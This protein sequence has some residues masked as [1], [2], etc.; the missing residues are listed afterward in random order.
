MKKHKKTPFVSALSIS[1]ALIAAGCKDSAAPSQREPDFGQHNQPLQVSNGLKSVVG[2]VAVLGDS[3]STGGYGQRLSELIRYASQQKLSYFGAASSGRIGSWINGGFAPIPANAF[4]G[5]DAY[6]SD[7]SCAPSTQ[8][9]KR[10][11]AIANIIAQHPYIDL[12]IITLGDNH[13]FDPASVKSELPRLI[14]P[15]LNAGARC[16][17]VSPTEGLGQFANK[18]TLISNLKAANESVQA[19]LGRS[20]TFIDSYTVGKDVLKNNSD[21]QLMRDAVAGDPMNLHPRGAGAKLWAER[22]FEALKLV[23]LVT[24]L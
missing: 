13:F 12:Y 3:Q 1:L 24:P 19:E 14:K 8:P 22:V 15:I 2:E 4:Y 9:G 7:K 6:T 16:A 5:C 18:T 11:E 20:C 21:L 10:T 17:F 23:N